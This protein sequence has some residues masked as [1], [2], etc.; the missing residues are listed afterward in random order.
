[1]F[2]EVVI[3]RYRLIS[4][5]ISLKPAQIT[6]FVGGNN[7]GKT[8]YLEAIGL[9]CPANLLSHL[10]SYRGHRLTEG[11][12]HIFCLD[13]KNPYYN[14]CTLEALV[15]SQHYK[16]NVER[17]ARYIKIEFVLDLRLVCSV[18]LDDQIARIRYDWTGQVISRIDGRALRHST[19]SKYAIENLQKLVQMVP[20]SKKV[21]YYQSSRDDRH[22]MREFEIGIVDRLCGDRYEFIQRI[23]DYFDFPKLDHI[24]I[25]FSNMTYLPEDRARRQARHTATE[26]E[27]AI[28]LLKQHQKSVGRRSWLSTILHEA[29]RIRKS[30]DP[31]RLAENKTGY[32]GL[33][34]MESQQPADLLGS[35]ARSVLNLCLQIEL[36][37]VILIDEPETFLHHSLQ[38]KLARYIRERAAEGKQFF[39]SSHS[40][41]FLNDLFGSAETAVIETFVDRGLPQARSITSKPG[42]LR[43]LDGLGIKASDILQTNCVIWL[44]GPSDRILMNR[45]I[46]LWSGGSLREGDHYSCL[47]YG[48]SLLNH[49]GANRNTTVGTTTIDMLIIN[50]NAIFLADSDRPSRDHP[51]SMAKAR[52]IQEVTAANGVAFLTD[53]RTIENYIPR[54]LLAELGIDSTEESFR[55]TNIRNI[56]GVMRS[57]ER[58]KMTKVELAQW[59]AGQLSLEDVNVDEP[60][61]SLVSEICAKIWACNFS[62]D[63]ALPFNRPATSVAWKPV[64]FWSHSITGSDEVIRPFVIQ[65]TGNDELSRLAVANGFV[66]M[67]TI[68][69]A[70]DIGL[71]EAANVVRAVRLLGF[72]LSDEMISAAV[73][74]AGLDNTPIMIEG[75]RQGILAGVAEVTVRSP[76]KGRAI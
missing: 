61:A 25:Q 64:P 33:R 56:I 45:W 50:R 72:D 55:F 10:Q 13:R 2:D 27:A 74:D 48:G 39:I 32:G 21:A 22:L 19:D 14:R 40:E 73:K 70:C 35:G 9:L 3:N 5:Q 63:E 30:I 34:L 75:V 51:I 23:C 24:G 52:V 17:Q 26:I 8:T 53:G 62:E 28:E 42:A 41:V 29:E 54:R 59:V 4:G 7:T 18:L 58:S 69:N 66:F 1:M 31:D 37:Q 49:F 47:F 44:E 60:L 57:K 67:M 15:K 46:E 20:V 36:N 12:G 16:V 6:L 11:L 65:I 76:A 68:R 71:R 38:R 43:V